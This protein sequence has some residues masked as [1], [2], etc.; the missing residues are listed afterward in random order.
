MTHVP[1]STVFSTI[2]PHSGHLP[3]LPRK[4][5]PHSTHRPATR[6]PSRRRF[7]QNRTAGTTPNPTTIA[8]YGTLTPIESVVYFPGL[9]FLCSV[10]NRNPATGSPRS[11]GNTIR[12]A[13][14][15][16]RQGVVVG[17]IPAGHVL[18]AQS[19]C[20]APD[21]VHAHTTRC[22]DCPTSTSTFQNI[23]ASSRLSGVR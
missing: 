10:Q 17:H 2:T 13:A 15:S 16:A 20:N 5:Y 8:Q 3:P 18:E 11:T 21:F 4:S 7:R 23:N 14:R 9:P 12:L 22:R 6:S 1:A 19:T